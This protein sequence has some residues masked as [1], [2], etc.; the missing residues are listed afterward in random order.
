MCIRG[1]YENILDTISVYETITKILYTTIVTAADIIL[2]TICDSYMNHVEWKSF[3]RNYRIFSK[4]SHLHDT[5]KSIYRKCHVKTSHFNH[6]K[7]YTLTKISPTIHMNIP[8]GDCLDFMGIKWFNFIHS[9][10]NHSILNSC[11]D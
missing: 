10:S 11:K 9:I 8:D 1:Y 5:R 3:C 7:L 6:G 2:G 4:F